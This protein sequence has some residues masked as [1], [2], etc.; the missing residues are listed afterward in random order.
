MIKL[1]R[2]VEL[3]RCSFGVAAGGRCHPGYV[4]LAAVNVRP[5]AMGEDKEG[6]DEGT[7]GRNK[8]GGVAT[9]SQAADTTIRSSRTF[10]ARP[11]SRSDWA[12]EV[13]K[14]A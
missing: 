9:Q 13:D 11:A 14:H 8:P 3:T 2:E 1:G 6:R 10:E 4:N 7:P 12:T 5:L